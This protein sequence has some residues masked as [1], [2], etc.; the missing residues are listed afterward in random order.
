MKSLLRSMLLA[1]LA[2]TAAIV[3][4]SAQTYPVRPVTIVT[5]YP[6][7]AASDTLARTLGEVLQSQWGQP[8]VIDTRAGSGGN[9]AASY[10]A[11]TAPDGHTLMV[12]TDAQLTSNAFLYKAMTFDPAK[13]F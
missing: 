7:G 11:R 13:D 12:A 8:V 2:T 5:G 3:A 1:L 10:V 9:L 4:A 6:A